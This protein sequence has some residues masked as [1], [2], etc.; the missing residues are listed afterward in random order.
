MTQRFPF[1]GT[2][3]QRRK[4]F[5]TLEGIC[6]K[7]QKEPTDVLSEALY[8]YER[9]LKSVEDDESFDEWG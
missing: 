7:Y 1:Y 5:E 8:E 3:R 2:D 9:V 6:S 4:F